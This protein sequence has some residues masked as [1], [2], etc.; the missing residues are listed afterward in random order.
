MYYVTNFPKPN[1]KI[2][3]YRYSE[4]Y[5]GFKN[6]NIYIYLRLHDQKPLSSGYEMFFRLKESW[7]CMDY[8]ILLM[9]NQHTK[10]IYLKLDEFK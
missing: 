4:R 7:K 1:Y 3:I 8:K 2:L 5:S 6:I 9:S 10:I